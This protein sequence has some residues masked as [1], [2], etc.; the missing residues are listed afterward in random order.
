MVSGLL[1]ASCGDEAN[2]REAFIRAMENQAELSPDVAECM[3]V[4]VFDSGDLTESEINQGARDDE[5]FGE[6]SAFR[7]VFDAALATCN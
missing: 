5:T 3:A 1:L 6:S 7:E 4:A 2:D